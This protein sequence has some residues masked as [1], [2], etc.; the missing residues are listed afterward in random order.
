MTNDAAATSEDNVFNYDLES[1]PR[2]QKVL[3]LTIGGVETSGVITDLSFAA[4]MGI[5]AWYPVP[6]RDKY[7]EFRRGYLKQSEAPTRRPRKQEKAA[8]VLLDTE[9]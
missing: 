8:Y 1:A 7:E 5:I 9:I 4:Q 2:G 6:K 3:L